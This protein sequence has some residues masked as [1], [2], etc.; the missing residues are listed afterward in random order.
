MDDAHHDERIIVYGHM[1]CAQAA[2][3]AQVLLEQRIPHE[4]RDVIDGDPRYQGELRA[5]AR[6][7][8]SVPTVIFPDASVMVEPWPGEV[9]K[10]LNRSRPGFLR[11]LFG[12]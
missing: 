8:L 1:R 9:L 7:H 5:L 12:R 10:R 2:W 3:L 6:G 4:W 11:Q